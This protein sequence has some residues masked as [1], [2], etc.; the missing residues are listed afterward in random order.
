MNITI[1]FKIKKLILYKIKYN[2][3][4]IKIKNKIIMK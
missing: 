3:L 4:I 2:L 1:K